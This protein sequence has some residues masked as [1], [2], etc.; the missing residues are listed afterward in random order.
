MAN[1]DYILLQEAYDQIVKN[2]FDI[3]TE[4]TAP[5]GV[6]N[7]DSKSKISYKPEILK[8]IDELKNNSDV[9]DSFFKENHPLSPEKEAAMIIETLLEMGLITIIQK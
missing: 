3:G 9:F 8:I 7:E 1:K 4:N 6:K 2:S 5:G